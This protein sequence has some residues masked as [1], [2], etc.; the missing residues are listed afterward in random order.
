MRTQLATIGNASVEVSSTDDARQWYRDT[1][2][3]NIAPMGIIGGREDHEQI[4]LRIT[5]EVNKE[6]KTKREE[7]FGCLP[8]S[9]A[10]LRLGT[11][12]R[13]SGDGGGGGSPAAGRRQG[14][15][16]GKLAEAEDEEHGCCAG[17]GLQGGRRSRWLRQWWTSPLF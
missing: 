16:D 5:N 14:E 6:D 2:N 11:P 3:T 9:R 15:S 1:N 4:R 7:R 13:R 8:R 10:P 12:T 17:L